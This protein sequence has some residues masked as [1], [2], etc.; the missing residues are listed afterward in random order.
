MTGL[1]T[2]IDLNGLTETIK[3]R[4]SLSEAYTLGA[5]ISALDVLNVSADSV[6]RASDKHEEDGYFLE[7]AMK[8]SVEESIATLN[9]PEG[10]SFVKMIA[11]GE[12]A[13]LVMIENFEISDFGQ[14]HS[15]Q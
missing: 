4:Y 15:V 1:K 2:N 12:P 3:K 11:P 9:A 13:L 8:K 10:F 5:V 6:V 7:D 14:H